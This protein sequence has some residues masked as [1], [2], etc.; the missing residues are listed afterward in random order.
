[1]KL[2]KQ[3]AILAAVTGMSAAAHAQTTVPPGESATRGEVKQDGSSTTS[4]RWP[5]RSSARCPSPR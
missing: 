1:M 2:L 3:V 4:S 5:T